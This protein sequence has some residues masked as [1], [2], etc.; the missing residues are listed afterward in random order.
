MVA[1]MP[2]RRP[3]F[4][5]SMKLKPLPGG[6]LSREPKRAM[7]AAYVNALADLAGPKRALAGLRDEP[8][9]AAYAAGIRAAL[10]Q[11][12]GQHINAALSLQQQ[13]QSHVASRQDVRGLR[14]VLHGFASQRHDQGRRS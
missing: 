13:P 14:K 8:R 6:W 10:A 3:T 11:R 9:L 2:H 4:L 12:P 1:A 5:P 7:L